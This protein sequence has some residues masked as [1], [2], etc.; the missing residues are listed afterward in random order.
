M[1]NPIAELRL[2]DARSK[3]AHTCTPL[4]NRL[5]EPVRGYTG[6]TSVVVYRII[7]RMMWLT[8][9]PFER[10]VCT[11]TGF[12][13]VAR[14]RVS[15]GGTEPGMGWNGLERVTRVHTRRLSFEALQMSPHP[16][17]PSAPAY[18]KTRNR[19][20]AQSLENY[21]VR[22]PSRK[23]VQYGLRMYDVLS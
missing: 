22:P 23:L 4:P 21:G 6:I 16:A 11:L 12:A 10:P 14:L 1:L 15:G 5:H 3:I 19:S 18:A 9:L 8:Q 13:G 17:T 7:A 2:S 20:S